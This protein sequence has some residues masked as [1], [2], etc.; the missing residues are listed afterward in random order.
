MTKRFCSI[1]KSNGPTLYHS[2]LQNYYSSEDK[3]RTG[4]D[5]GYVALTNSFQNGLCSLIFPNLRL[6]ENMSNLLQ[7]RLVM[8]ET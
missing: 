4:F 2:G 7:P 3:H 6:T 1:N 8:G 5:G